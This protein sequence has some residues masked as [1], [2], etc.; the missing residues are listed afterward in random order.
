MVKL[1]LRSSTWLFT[2]QR[3]ARDSRFAPPLFLAP[4]PP[5]LKLSGS[6]CPR[7][8]AES[9]QTSTAFLQGLKKD[10]A[11]TEKDNETLYPICSALLDNETRSLVTNHRSDI[12]AFEVGLLRIERSKGFAGFRWQ[13]SDAKYAR[14]AYTEK[15]TIVTIV[16]FNGGGPG[17]LSWLYCSRHET[18]CEFRL[19][20]MHW[21][22]CFLWVNEKLHLG[23]ALHETLAWNLEAESFPAATSSYWQCCA[24]AN[25]NHVYET[26]KLWIEIV[27]HRGH[28]PGW[29][30]SKNVPLRLFWQ[31]C[32]TQHISRAMPWPQT[33]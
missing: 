6:L 11:F 5:R 24:W 28:T 30:H 20:K 3:V 31:V 19:E 27:Q 15:S 2:G 10:S 21:E 23:Q 22:W 18:P 32:A 7:V 33:R 1:Q 14:E 16:S 17:T 12:A 29:M 4:T 13:M 9:R 25:D 8:L 26:P